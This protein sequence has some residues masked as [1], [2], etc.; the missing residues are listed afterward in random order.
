MSEYEALDY[1]DPREDQRLLSRRQYDAWTDPT[2]LTLEVLKRELGEPNEI[3]KNGNCLW[4]FTR[5]GSAAWYWERHAEHMEYCT[6]YVKTLGQLRRILSVIE[7]VNQATP[8][9]GPSDR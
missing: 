5:A 1:I 9:G 3:Q 7:E 8:E 2:P 4:G 6:Q